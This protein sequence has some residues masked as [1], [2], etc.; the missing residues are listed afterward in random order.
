MILR[1]T[2]VKSKVRLFHKLAAERLIS[3]AFGEKHVEVINE[4]AANHYNYSPHPQ[5]APQPRSNCCK[6][7][8]C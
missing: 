4:A 3:H 5:G 8:R 2:M 1:L 6:F 7:N